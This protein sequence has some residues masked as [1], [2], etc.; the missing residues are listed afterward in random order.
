MAFTVPTS[1]HAVVT[2]LYFCNDLTKAGYH[3]IMLLGKTFFFIKFYL[4]TVFVPKI[5]CQL[6]PEKKLLQKKVNMWKVTSENVIA[7]GIS[8]DM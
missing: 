7:S 6:F 2:T 5:I 1:H 4:A 3:K 8:P